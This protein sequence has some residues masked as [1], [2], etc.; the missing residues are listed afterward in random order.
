MNLDDRGKLTDHVSLGVLTRIVPR[1]VV[2][3]VIAETGRVEKRSR[4]LPAH[5]VVYFVLAL[6]LFTDG[7]EEV[8]RKLVHGLRFARTWS[9]EWQTPT[10]GALSQARARLGEEPLQALF[11]TV[12]V[13]IA[14]AGTPGAWLRNW[15]LMAL[16]GV[17]ID[18]PDTPQNRA[19][20]PKP[21]GGTRRPFPQ[22]RTVGLTEV[23]THAVIA[24]TIGTIRTGERELAQALLDSIT[25]DMLVVADRGFYSFDLWRN[26][27]FTG[28]T[29][30]GGCRPGFDFPF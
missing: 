20:F 22:S 3:E 9:K 27:R 10:T 13:P 26:Y 4:L 1:Y 16:D 12:A 23:G 8:I 24:I 18:M 29:C 5:V 11:E 17:M 21:E 19:V 28:R 6:S 30:C 14:K 15:R 25:P 7:Y 2:D